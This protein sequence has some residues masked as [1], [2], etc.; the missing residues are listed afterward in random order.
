MFGLFRGWRR[1][2]LKK[3]PFPE[4][5]EQ[6]LNE[7]FT[8]FRMLPV[9]DQQ[10]LRKSVQIFVA[11]KHWEAAKGFQ[12]TEEMK[13][14]VAAQACVLTLGFPGD[15]FDNLSSV[16]LFEDEYSRKT[17]GLER[18]GW[19]ASM[20][21]GVRYGEAML[22]GPVA[23]SWEDT[24]RG[25]R[26]PNDGFNLVYHEFAHILDFA[27]FSV[28][29]IPSAFG[30]EDLDRWKESFTREYHNHVRATR[31]GEHTLLGRYAATNPAEF[32]AVGTEVFFE[33]PRLMQVRLPQLFDLF[34][35]FYRQN[36]AEWKA[37]ETQES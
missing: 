26:I 28:D 10:E 19:V 4:Q 1:G 6:W 15:Y 2:R 13:V 30:L 3:K 31:Q 21:T 37:D 5:W 14:I 12:L 22:H 16:I 27:D 36:P 32:L 9:E 8:Q 33:K 25:A 34:R 11:E 35:E 7:N 20:E 29:G 17:S 23:L 18:R 24:L